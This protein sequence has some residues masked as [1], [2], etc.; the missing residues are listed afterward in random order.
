MAEDG[1]F[2]AGEHRCHP[3]P[4]P[5]RGAMSHRVDAAVDAVQMPTRDAI[6]DRP[7]SQTCTFE[8]PPR[9]DSVLSLRD[10]RHLEIGCVDFLTHVGT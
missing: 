7:R 4:V 10:P 2:A 3:A 6:S 5:A 9:N 8:L 1:A